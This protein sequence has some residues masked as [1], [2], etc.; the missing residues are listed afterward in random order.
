MIMNHQAT[1]SLNTAHLSQKMH[2]KWRRSSLV[3]LESPLTVPFFPFD[4]AVTIPYDR[5]VPLFHPIKNSVLGLSCTLIWIPRKHTLLKHFEQLTTFSES[6]VEHG[7]RNTG[8][9]CFQHGGTTSHLS[10]EMGLLGQFITR[11]NGWLPLNA[12][13]PICWRSTLCIKL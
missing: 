8:G 2:A 7:K 9:V 11:S 10:L 6:K 5:A 12:L 1:G 3:P 13:N 4:A